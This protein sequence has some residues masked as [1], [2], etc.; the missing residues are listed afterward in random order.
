MTS[1]YRGYC[2][3]PGYISS[4][5]QGCYSL[6]GG[7]IIYESSDAEVSEVAPRDRPAKSLAHICSACLIFI[8]H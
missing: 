3:R 1:W 4:K 2:L 7:D 5:D 6:R 8:S